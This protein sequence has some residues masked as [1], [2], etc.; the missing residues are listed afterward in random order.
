MAL[1]GSATSQPVAAIITRSQTFWHHDGTTGRERPGPAAGSGQLK[2][3]MP[4]PLLLDHSRVYNRFGLALIYN[5]RRTH[6]SLELDLNLAT[7][8]MI[9]PRIVEA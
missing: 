6:R 7:V 2:G 1:S 8:V 9:H 4:G 5:G 3:L